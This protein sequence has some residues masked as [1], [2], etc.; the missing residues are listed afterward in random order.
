[1]AARTTHRFRQWLCTRHHSIPTVTVRRFLPTAVASRSRPCGTDR[2][3]DR[4]DARR[5]PGALPTVNS[6]CRPVGWGVARAD[7]RHVGRG[8]QDDRGTCPRPIRDGVAHRAPFARRGR[9]EWLPRPSL[10]RRWPADWPVSG[11]RSEPPPAL[12]YAGRGL[13]FRG[14][15]RHLPDYDH[16]GR[17]RAGRR[18]A[19]A[20]QESGA[21]FLEFLERSS[22][23]WG[24][25]PGVSTRTGGHSARRRDRPG[26]SSATF[27]LGCDVG[28]SDISAHRLA[29]PSS[30]S[31]RTR[32]SSTSRVSPCC[33]SRPRCRT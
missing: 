21:G 15:T 26:S 3:A 29:S 12:P 32:C 7:D 9:C 5:Q 1:M 11:T 22:R 24:M 6:Y 13:A 33:I 23:R 27:E 31:P 14:A 4:D 10:G 25:R 16:Q 8:Q 20:V 19:P 17:R 2:R 18:C 30:A 28:A